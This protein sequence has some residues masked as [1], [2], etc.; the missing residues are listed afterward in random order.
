[1]CGRCKTIEPFDCIVHPNA[2][3]TFSLNDQDVFCIPVEC[4]ACKSDTI[5]SSFGALVQSC[6]WVGRSEFEEV[7]V[8][9]Y[10]PKAHRKFYS[11]ATIAYQ[12]GQTLAEIFLLRTLIEQHMGSIVNDSSKMRGDELC[13]KHA[14]TLP[15][16]F[17]QQVSSLKEVY[18]KL[19]GSMH[20]ALG[21]AELFEA[22]RGEIERHFDAL[23]LFK[24][25]RS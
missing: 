16:N 1:M 18:A 12:A 4:Q 8:S 9:A 2:I 20:G 25:H 11:Q 19:S 5:V 17:K 21:D 15:D 7:A 6:N 3:Q 13:E 23:R 10:I 14:D 24:I 22:Q